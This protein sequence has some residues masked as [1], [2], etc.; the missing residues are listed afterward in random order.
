VG[1]YEAQ[2]VLVR[3]F[4]SA[5]SS[6]TGSKHADSIERIERI[7][8]FEGQGH[9]YLHLFILIFLRFARL[10]HHH[11]LCKGCIPFPR[12]FGNSLGFVEG[13]RNDD[14]GE[15]DDGDIV[16]VGVPF[17]ISPASPPS[18]A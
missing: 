11:R 16:I 13:I 3:M 6:D 10:G 1:E 14:I 7:R 2:D 12:L 4:I 5:V 8:R 9:T 15:D 17:A 18:G